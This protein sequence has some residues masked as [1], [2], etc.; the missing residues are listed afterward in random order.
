PTW[1]DQKVYAFDLQGNVKT[2][3]P[4]TAAYPIWSTPAIGDLDGDGKK[5]IVF[6]SNG[7]LLYALRWYGQ[8]WIDGDANP[9]TKGVFKVLGAPYNYGTPALADLNGDGHLDIVFASWDGNLYAWNSNGTNLPGFPIDMG[10]A[11]NASVAIGK[12]DGPGD[13]TPEI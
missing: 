7:N 1:N 11:S 6:G 3:W 12:L 4:F 8:E 5:E 9:A 10:G 13:T 2:G